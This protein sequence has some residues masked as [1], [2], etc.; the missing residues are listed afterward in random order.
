MRTIF[1]YIII[2][3]ITFSFQSF[4]WNN[5]DPSTAAALKK[6]VA[7]FFNKNSA[8]FPDIASQEVTV[9]FMINA[10]NEIIVLDVD[11]ASAAACDFVK[12]VLS[13]RKVKYN[14]SRQLTRYNVKIHLIKE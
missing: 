2:L 12:E 3:T 4:S 11:C 14:Q 13:Y 6:E 8:N 5:D 9:G 10:K 7:Q 1:S